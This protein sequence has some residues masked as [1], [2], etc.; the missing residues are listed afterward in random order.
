MKIKATSK[1]DQLKVK[2]KLPSPEVIDREELDLIC[3][4][5]VRGFLKP[6]LY[7][8]KILEYKGTGG[9]SLKKYLKKPLSKYE[10][11]FAIHQIVLAES[12]I[13]KSGL[14][15]NR[16]WLNFNAVFI[17]EAT[18]ELLFIYL[19]AKEISDN[20]DVMTFLKS[21][22]KT[23]KPICDNA[24]YDFIS[25]F[26]YFISS[27]SSFDGLKIEKYIERENNRITRLTK[28]IES[29]QMQQSSDKAHLKSVKSQKVDGQDEE[30]DIIDSDKTELLGRSGLDD[31]EQDTS[32]LLLSDDVTT[33]LGD[34]D[35]TDLI[36]TDEQTELV[37]YPTLKRI[38]T[39]EIIV[40]NKS[41]FRLGKDKSCVDYVVTN[42]NTISGSHADIV[43]RNEQY[44][45]VDLNSKN[46]TYINKRVLPSQYEVEIFSGDTLRLSN[47]DF[48]FGLQ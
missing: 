48:I 7:K 37:H 34:D 31:S 15:S 25:R 20:S 16:L 6:S 40:I 10:F 42:N 26:M 8:T 32:T 14:H 2:I 46:K 36:D 41:V 44:Y 39:D 43:S 4:V 28:R 29:M 17:N 9:V 19:P 21:V 33:L 11:F 12:T 27:M 47:E 45:V 23:A 3:R 38:S 5:F 18:K 30:T 35:S 22:A 13:Q 24:D 1:K